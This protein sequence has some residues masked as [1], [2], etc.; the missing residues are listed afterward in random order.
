MDRST[1]ETYL[2]HALPGYRKEFK[3]PHWELAIDNALRAHS[4]SNLDAPEIATGDE[5]KVRQ[6]ALYYALE[7]A[8]RVAASRVT[9]SVGNPPSSKAAGD[10]YERIRNLRIEQGRVLAAKGILLV[11]SSAILMTSIPVRYQEPV[12]SEGGL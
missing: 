11:T 1:L 9:I 6:L 12:D 5:E 4:V 10:A 3:L 7:L 8:E 2:D